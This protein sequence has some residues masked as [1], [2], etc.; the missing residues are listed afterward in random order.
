MALMRLTLTTCLAVVLFLPAADGEVVVSSV[1]ISDCVRTFRINS[2]ESVITLSYSPEFL[3]TNT[4]RK[5]FCGGQYHELISNN[6]VSFHPTKVLL[7]LAQLKKK[8]PL[9]IV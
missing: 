7:K 6:S 8:Y 2:L 3:C 1:S 9:K 5:Q 4:L